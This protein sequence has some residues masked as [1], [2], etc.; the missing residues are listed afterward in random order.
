MKLKN[1]IVALALGLFG[2]GLATSCDDMLDY[3]DGANTAVGKLDNPSD[4]A[5]YVLGIISKM[6]ASPICICCMAIIHPSI[7]SLKRNAGAV[8]PRLESN[9]LPLMV[10]PV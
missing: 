3:E 10:L 8:P 7:R 2:L 1:Y 4:T 5:T 6:Q 9:F